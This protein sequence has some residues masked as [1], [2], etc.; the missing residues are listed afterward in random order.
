MINIMVGLGDG[1]T[2]TELQEEVWLWW[3]GSATVLFA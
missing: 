1:R 3:P 2:G